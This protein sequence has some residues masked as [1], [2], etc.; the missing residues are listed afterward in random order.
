MAEKEEYEYGQPIP[1]KYRNRLF[2]WEG[3]GYDGCIW[4][5]NVGL[6]DKDGHWIPIYS[7]G[8]DGIDQ[9][10]WYRRKIENLKA[11]F[12]YDVRSAKMQFEEVFHKAVEKVFGKKWYEV[13]GDPFAD[14][15]VKKLVEKDEKRYNEFVRLLYGYNL[16]RKQRLDAMFMQVVG[17]GMSRDKFE[18]IGLIDESH[19]KETC[20]AFCERYSGNVGLMTHALDRMASIGY[21]VWCTCSDC[22][23]QFQPCDY[24]TFSC[25]MDK[26]AYTGDGGIGVIMKRVLC[27]E[28]HQNAECRNCFELDKPNCNK[29]D[30]GASD[31]ENYDFLACVIH[32]WLDVCWGCASGFEC[33]HLYYWDEAANQRFRTKLGIEYDKMEEN[34]KRG[35]GLDGHELYDEIVKTP[36]GRKK[37]NKIR[38]L[39]HEAIVAHFS[40]NMDEYWFDDRLETYC[41]GQMTLPGVE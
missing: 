6:V 26:D 11:D 7:S 20:K 4:E 38:D 35:Y 33:D 25:S 40:S 37:I 8:S 9:D 31:W 13:E 29:K 23:E 21:G 12:G 36:G 41:P 19:I 10:D 24:E 22:G 30:E 3:G 14:Q 28:C 15:R 34:L 27:D 5:P 16:E 2:D 18:E 1:P 32:E 39:L 17:G